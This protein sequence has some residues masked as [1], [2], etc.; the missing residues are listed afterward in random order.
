MKKIV[1]LT[2]M[3]AIL[4]ILASC[5]ASRNIVHI[6]NNSETAFMQE[7]EYMRAIAVG[8]SFSER[9]ARDEARR[10]AISALATRVQFT[11]EKTIYAYNRQVSPSDTL[12]KI[13]IHQ[14]ISKQFYD[15][16]V[17]E[18]RI[19]ATDSYILSNGSFEYYVCVEMP[20]NKNTMAE[21]V[22][23]QISS[24]ENIAMRL[25]QRKFEEE[26]ANALKTYPSEE[27]LN[28]M[29]EKNIKKNE[30]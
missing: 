3:T 12:S 17:R 8:R 26:L 10:K 1:L 13:I 5:G 20:K 2:T 16:V 28:N 6:P 27:Y 4:F 19:I 22:L 25:D 9:I 18:S 11:I 23:N 29:T 14:R 15:E 24:D 30:K 21:S 7:S